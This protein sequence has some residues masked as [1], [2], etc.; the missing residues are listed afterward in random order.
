MQSKIVAS[1]Q[2][3]SHENLFAA[4]E[5]HHLIIGPGDKM[6]SAWVAAGLELPDM[7]A[8]RRYRVGRTVQQ[9][10][11]MGYDGLIVT[12]PMN[13]RY[14]SDATNM[15]LWVMHNAT[16]YA[17]VGADGYVIVWDYVGCEFLSG[18][19]EVIDEVRPA[20]GLNYFVA[21]PRRAEMAARWADELIELI[22][23]RVGPNARI[24]I[25]HATLDAYRA[26]E[27]AGLTIGDGQQVMELARRIKGPD[28]VKAMR[29]SVHACQATMS[30]MLEALEPGM[31][32]RD[33]WAMLHAGNIR[34]AGEWIETQIISSGPRTNPWMQEASSRVINAGEMLA[35]DTDLV[36]P[37]GMM[38]DISRSW[39][40]GDVEP[41]DHQK[42][43]HDMATDQLGRNADLLTPG[44]TFH[45]LTH[46]AWFPPVDEYRHYSVLFHGVGQCDEYPCI[47]FPDSW[48]EYGYDDV[49]EPGMCFTAESFIG[50]RGGGEGIKLE[51]QYLVTET[52]PELLTHFPLEL[53]R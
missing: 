13:I 14:V 36:G 45:E 50:D 3:R 12:D 16:R 4:T 40:V 20:T 38:T 18:H 22:A 39:V 21:G 46:K 51:N 24:A 37:Y 31:T 44:H 26:L 47:Y 41:N 25:D 43:L 35:Y 33:V 48:D 42:R 28:E 9:L 30:E 8:L 5:G 19:S 23:E 34:R 53:T 32:E 29:C 10:S 1:L 11:A 7:A 17:W 2:D 15:Q 52:G 27:S 49:I 6:T